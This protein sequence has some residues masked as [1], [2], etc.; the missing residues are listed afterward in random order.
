MRWAI[1]R[2][3]EV[4][5]R[6]EAL[7]RMDSLREAI[8]RGSNYLNRDGTKRNGAHNCWKWGLNRVPRCRS[9]LDM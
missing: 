1:Q 2:G 8:E 3:L 5:I 4:E 6:R 7:E 9:L